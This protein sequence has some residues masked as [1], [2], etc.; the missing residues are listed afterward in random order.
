M[1]RSIAAIIFRVSDLDAA[2]RFY[3]DSLGLSLVRK[4]SAS[5][6]AEFDVGGTRLALQQQTPPGGGDN[7]TL[8]LWAH[9][10]DGT[11]QILKSRGVV[12][13]DTEV[14]HQDFGRLIRLR[15]PDGNVITLFE[16][17]D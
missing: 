6:W 10:L 17:H 2:C 11:V 12:F 15:D 13:I 8:S 14:E 7:P 1:I 4:H 9:N 16:G 5:G 3:R